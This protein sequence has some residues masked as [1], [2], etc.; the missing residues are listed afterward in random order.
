MS[1]KNIWKLH[2]KEDIYDWYHF[3]NKDLTANNTSFFHYEA[4]LL[5]EYLNNPTLDEEERMS[6]FAK[7]WENFNERKRIVQRFLNKKNTIQYPD[8]F[9]ESERIVIDEITINFE[10]II[11]EINVFKINDQ[12][13]PFSY[14]T[15]IKKLVKVI[16]KEQVL[17]NKNILII[18]TDLN[19][20]LI[21]VEYEINKK[22]VSKELKLFK[23]LN[24]YQHLYPEYSCC[25][26]WLIVS[27]NWQDMLLQSTFKKWVS[28]MNLINTYS[29]D[30]IRVSNENLIKS[31]GLISY[32]ILNLEDG[33]TIDDI[34]NDNGYDR[35][36]L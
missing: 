24:K 33:Y 18:N 3:L 4:N 28:C 7:C 1:F 5:N 13:I 29:N 32:L 16:I 14:E 20:N 15:L 34:M 12:K 26:A 25:K 31:G 27:K 10:D 21:Y 17:K 22:T 36:M 23:F 11:N 9:N 8:C 2:N 19:K 30:T 35:I 6:K